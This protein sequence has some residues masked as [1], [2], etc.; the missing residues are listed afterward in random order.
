MAG[1]KRGTKINRTPPPTGQERDFSF[2]RS[3]Y[4]GN[5]YSGPSSTSAPG[6]NVTSPLSDDIKA[7]GTDGVL[8]E[9]IRNGTAKNDA[10]HGSGPDGV[11][12]QPRNISEK[13]VPDAAGMKSSRN[14]QCASPGDTGRSGS[15]PSSAPG[16]VRTPGGGPKKP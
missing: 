2:A 1:N 13:N 12:S 15:L 9:V 11:N 4:G 14:R 7:A 5:A 10:G 16:I 3:Q 6:L 8:D